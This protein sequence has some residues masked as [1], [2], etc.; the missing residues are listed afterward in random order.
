MLVTV[1][2]ALWVIGLLFM[3]YLS[4]TINN[5]RAYTTLRRKKGCSEIK[6]YPH[7]EPFLG[8]DM[9]LEFA[10]SM[11]SRKVMSTIEGYFLKY[12]KTFQ[13]NSWGTKVINT[14][15]PRI[16]QTVLALEFD[17][18]G[19]EPTRK[20]ALNPIMQDGIFV[21]DGSKWVH[22]RASVKQI[23]SGVR[24]SSVVTMERH[25]ERLLSWIPR[26]GST[27]DLQPLL[28]RL[29]SDVPVLAMQEL[30]IL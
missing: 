27:V 28:K 30:I 4:R 14:M 17:K 22:S 8:L 23:F 9:F 3:L 2:T 5:Q 11:Q 7:R 19:V 15:D 25:V 20:K 10:K 6:K 24:N 13:S 16:I 21:S 29:V 12:G 1:S 18:F 26:D